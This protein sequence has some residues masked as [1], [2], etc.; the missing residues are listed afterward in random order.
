MNSCKVIDLVRKLDG[1]IVFLFLGVNHFIWNCLAHL[2][3]LTVIWRNEPPSNFCIWQV[4]IQNLLWYHIILSSEPSVR[5]WLFTI[6]LP[7]FAPSSLLT[8]FRPFRTRGD[9]ST[10]FDCVLPGIQP[11]NLWFHVLRI[12]FHVY[13]IYICLISCDQRCSL[14]FN[15]FDSI[16]LQPIFWKLSF[17]RRLSWRVVFAL[18]SL[19]WW[20]LFF[21]KPGALFIVRYRSILFCQAFL[22]I[23]YPHVIKVL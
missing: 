23:W 9:R 3:L 12:F 14:L 2:F 7:I 15:L 22:N 17:F 20:V 6:I 11:L 21:N 18:L 1:K 13:F 4:V 10:T 16:R 5:N 19:T 8:R